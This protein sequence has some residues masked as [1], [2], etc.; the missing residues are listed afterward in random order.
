[1]S[2]QFL[3]F[4]I[5]QFI[6]TP[7]LR[8]KP[9][10]PSLYVI[11][12]IHD[13]Y[14][15]GTILFVLFF[16]IHRKPIIFT[17]TT[18]PPS[19]EFAFKFH[20]IGSPKNTVP[21]KPS[22]YKFSF[23]SNFKRLWKILRFFVLDCKWSILTLNT[24]FAPSGNSRIPKPVNNPLKKDP[25]YRVESGNIRCPKPCFWPFSFQSP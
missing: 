19:S 3:R 22:T 24:Y 10:L 14:K 11:K 8:G 15:I 18:N 1:M 7:S 25:S 4:T 17:I 12:P 2:V 13:Q 5:R 9:W 21:M 16:C 6:N 20:T 23:V